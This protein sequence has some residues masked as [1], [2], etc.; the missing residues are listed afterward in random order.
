[1]AKL[2]INELE[3]RY[4][5]VTALKEIHL[6]IEEGEILSLLGGNGAGKTT[7]INSVTG[8]VKPSR[9]TIS[10]QNER[11]EGLETHHIVE[12]GLT[13]VPEGRR[14]FPLMTV[15]DN[16]LIGAYTPRAERRREKNLQFVLDLLPVL[17]ERK[18]QVAKTLSGGE[19]QMLAIGRALMA[20]PSLLILDE[21]SLGLAPILVDT[22]FKLI[23][24]INGE[25]KTIFLVEQ[26][27]QQSL[28]I[29][30]RGYVLE[31]GRT[32]VEGKSEVLLED[33]FVKEAYLGL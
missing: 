12:K 1:M 9:G 22:I 23:Q 15:I 14:L 8:L 17:R 25:G 7:L 10:F 3:V 16:L 19:Q 2:D 27:V 29:S 13:Q 4:G 24:D 26:N 31:N 18:K 5:D 32:V 11:I 33:Q 20:D 30:N 28:E 6:T 21:P